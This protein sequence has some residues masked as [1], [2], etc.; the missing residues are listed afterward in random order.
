[1]V[2]AA[3]WKRVVSGSGDASVSPFSEMNPRQVE[4]FHAL[5][6]DL[7]LSRT[8]VEILVRRGFS[9]AAAVRRY[10]SPRLADLTDPRP[11]VDRAR[12]AQRIAQA[13]TERQSICVFGDYDCDGITSTAI[14]TEIVTQLGGKVVPLLANRFE[15]GY[16][17]GPQSVERIRAHA[18]QLLI[19][20]DCGSSEHQALSVLAASGIEAVVIDHHLVPDE[21]LPAVAFLN[22]HRPECGFPF[23]G[24]ASCGLVLNVAA[25]V[26]AELGVELDVREWLDLVAVGTIAD[27]A[28]LV[29]D[30]RALVRAGLRSLRETKRPG[31]RALMKQARV[32]LD[33]PL[34]AEDVAFRI[35]PRLNAPGRLESPEPALALLL[36]RD[37]EVAERRAAE[38]EAYQRRR[39]SLQDMM[40]DE[41]ISEIEQRGWQQAPALVVARSNWSVGIV[42]IVAGKLSERFACP[43]VVIGMDGVV[44]RGSVRVPRGVR[45]HDLLESV[46]DCLLRFGGHQAAAGLDVAGDRID[47]FRT[48]FTQAADDARGAVSAAAAE[49]R[50]WF[51]LHPEDEPLTVARELLLLEPCGEGNR[52]PTIAVTAE[53]ACARDLRGGHL[54]VDLDCSRGNRIEAF[55]PNMGEQAGT[56]RGSVLA[57]GTLRETRYLDRARAELRL[58]LIRSEAKVRSSPTSDTPRCAIEPCPGDPGPS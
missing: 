38:V 27:V 44:G 39:R 23:K 5:L 20:C 51:P 11:M 17:L 1:M 46:K 55:G 48:R 3:W 56:L 40:V 41:A 29:G 57:L 35:A 42:G 24:L 31:L 30:N 26:R 54:R 14:L 4:I 21:P 19:T 52:A 25:A 32:V 28:P 36:E 7:G 37:P 10:L 34:T 33:G 50:E 47:E 22:P 8:L 45:A 6:G 15:G 58:Q 13:I 9:D 18:P 49:P 2:V 43:A 12:A 53:V 16:G